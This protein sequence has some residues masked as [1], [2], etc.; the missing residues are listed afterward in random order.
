MT[1]PEVESFKRQAAEEKERTIAVLALKI[2]PAVLAMPVHQP[3][4]ANYLGLNPK[5]RE[6]AE[7][8]ALAF[9]YAEALW[10]V[11]AERLAAL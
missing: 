1:D 8:A 7:C 9:M 4:Y 6:P 11:S 2:L 10:N 3:D 5:T